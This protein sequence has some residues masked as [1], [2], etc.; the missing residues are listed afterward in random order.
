MILP[1]KELSIPVAGN[2]RKERV[3]I[4]L[5]EKLSGVSRSRVKQLIDAGYVKIDDEIVKP[6]RLVNPG[7]VIS[8]YFESRPGPSF[9]PE[10]IPLD[11]VYEDEHVI[12]VNKDAGIVVHPAHGNWSG[13]LMNALLG[14][15]E[16]L[17]ELGQEFRAGIVHRLDKDTSGLLI[18]AK[19]EYTLSELGKQ[20]RD[21]TIE[22]NYTALVWGHPKKA[23]GVIEKKLGRSNKDRK[24]FTVTEDGKPANTGY[25]V[26]E[27]FDLF[28]LLELKLGTGRTH[29]IRV[30]MFDMGNPVFGDATYGGRNARF[31]NLT[32]VERR[33]CAGYLEVMQ[34]QAL[35]AKTLKFYHPVKKEIMSFDSSLPDDFVTVIKMIKQDQTDDLL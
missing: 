4:Y 17:K 19:D 9:E 13:T 8:V 35:H 22:R 20:F 1:P 26:V 24:V 12:I 21:R 18:S 30:H 25:K 33:K 16:K 14:H 28:S 11:I 5:V 27:R 7:E 23:S 31:G 2:Q 29:Q 32:Q 6:S 15:N 10:D 3:D 34:R